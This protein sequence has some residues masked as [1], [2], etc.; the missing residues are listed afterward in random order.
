LLNTAAA[1]KGD[2]SKEA[3]LR[4]H[5]ALEA[6]FPAEFGGAANRVRRADVARFYLALVAGNRRT[7]SL[8]TLVSSPHRFVEGMVVPCVELARSGFLNAEDKHE[9]ESIGNGPAPPTGA[10]STTRTTPTTRPVGVPQCVLDVGAGN[11]VPG[12]LTPIILN[13]L[14]LSPTDRRSESIVHPDP[15]ERPALRKANR[16]SQDWLQH[17]PQCRDE[18]WLLVEMELRKIKFLREAISETNMDPYVQT[19]HC[20]ADS[21]L[22]NRKLFDA[23]LR[24]LFPMMQPEFQRPGWMDRLFPRMTVVSQGLGKLADLWWI[25]KDLPGWDS[26]V[27]LKG[28]E[29]WAQEWDL[30][31]STPTKEK[32]LFLLDRRDYVTHEDPTQPRYRTIVKLWRNPNV[33][34]DL[35]TALHG[36]EKA[37][38]SSA[39]T[40]MAGVGSH[41]AAKPA[42]REL[43]D[44]GFRGR[45]GAEDSHDAEGGVAWWKLRD[46]KRERRRQM[47]KTVESLRSRVV[48]RSEE[49]YKPLVGGDPLKKDGQ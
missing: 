29:S 37:P 1:S 25:L 20:R 12:V 23:G 8:T 9:Q 42:G 30:F 44:G 15:A 16:A 21:I 31:D 35:H 11:G 28:P 24:M 33:I 27:L 49:K 47:M 48:K 43:N 26:M 3:L 2:D 14:K 45:S 22:K 18:R 5:E 17:L 40:L 7:S 41:D 36:K 39:G 38:R 4:L 6:R 13:A 10:P 19:I 32:R 34:P 46:S